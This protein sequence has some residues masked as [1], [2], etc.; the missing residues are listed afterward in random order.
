MPRL[1]A[2]GGAGTPIAPIAFSAWPSARGQRSASA[3]SVSEYGRLPRRLHIAWS[4]LGQHDGERSVE[5]QEDLPGKLRRLTDPFG[6]ERRAQ[7]ISNF[8]PPDTG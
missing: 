5:Q 2:Q 7:F 3:T 4:R 6:F 1:L 8:R